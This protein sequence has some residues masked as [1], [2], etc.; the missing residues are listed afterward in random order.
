MGLGFVVMD[1]V[2]YLA[3]RSRGAVWEEVIIHLPESVTVVSLSATV[4]QRRGVRRV[5]GHGAR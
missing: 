4:S 3:D 1:E 2:H 5:A